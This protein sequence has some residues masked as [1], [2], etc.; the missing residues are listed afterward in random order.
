M[1]ELGIMNI[2]ASLFGIFRQ[3]G[4]VSAIREGK[5]LAGFTISALLVSILGGALYGLAMGAGLGIDTAIKDSLKIGLIVV[6]GL[7]F[8]IPIF[9][10]AYR[11][12][13]REE[14]LAQVAAIPL[15][16]GA[17]VSILLAITSPIVF[18]LSVL[19]GFNPDAIYIHIVII[20]LALI[21]GLYLAGTVIYYA[22]PDR[23][24]LITPNVIG[25]LMLGVIIV[26]LMNFLSPFL[27][28]QPTFSVGTDRLKDGLGIGVAQRADHALAA[29]IAADHIS[30]K[31]QTTNQNG[32]M[33]QEYIITRVGNDYLIDVHLHAI[34]DEDFT[35]DRHIWILD[36]QFYT[37]FED[38]RVSQA[39]LKEIT[40]YL[41]PAL[42][43][44]VF[45]LTPDFQ[46]ANWRAYESGSWYTITGTSQNMAQISLILGA[47]SGR[48]SEFR[49]GSSD[50]SLK[51]ST[52]ITE[53]KTATIDRDD[54]EA[55]LNQAIVLG[56]VEKTDA[57]MKS[58]SQEDTFF[59]LQYPTT[60]RTGSWSSDQQQVKFTS[61]CQDG[62]DC[63]NLL[64]SVW[65]L[66][67]DKR[68]QQ[69]AKD[70]G[71]SLDLQP[72]YTEIR[73]RTTL[74]GD[75]TVGVVE[76]IDSQSVKGE[77]ISREH[78]VYIFVGQNYR[79]H[80]DFSAPEAEYEEYSEL[81]KVIAEQLTFLKDSL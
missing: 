77:L 81:F 39:E 31:F 56:S 74:I 44:N 21:V 11:L 46:T 78:I 63:P 52:H 42:P 20:D 12:L 8:S 4:L 36:D 40:S 65:E 54:L 19:A 33:I 70:L 79:Y 58:F 18:M 57:S 75:Q 10:V 22:F 35:A 61:P 73:S 47:S 24:Q 50:K 9:W 71:S 62:E 23:K 2:F 72:Q 30:Y 48:L 5:Q 28:I 32:D 7:L 67:E 16:L 76:Y 45:T 53:I 59:V 1:E 34:P 3:R 25:F 51:S 49:L 68:A 41:D 80:L 13:G 37:D 64:L 26:V 38:G 69:Y 27:S 6:L 66:S 17:T 14:K 15:T 29:A 60:W 55:S 43:P